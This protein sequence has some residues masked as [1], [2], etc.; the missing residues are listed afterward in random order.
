MAVVPA[1]ELDEGALAATDPGDARALSRRDL[2]AALERLR[3]D[4]RAAL[5][6]TYGQELTHEEAAAVLECPLGTLK[7]LVA[8]AKEKL[9]RMLHPHAEEAS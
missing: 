6:L 3:P 7:S 2:E 1:E 5:A 4:E 9:R 8:R